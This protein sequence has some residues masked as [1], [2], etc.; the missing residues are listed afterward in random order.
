MST[1][2]DRI[3]SGSIED[4][5]SVGRGTGC[6]SVRTSGS[7]GALAGNRQ[8]HPARRRLGLAPAADASFVRPENGGYSARPRN[9]TMFPRVFGTSVIASLK[10]LREIGWFLEAAEG[11]HL[12]A[13]LASR[14][15]QLL[16]SG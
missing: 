13:S 11:S 3:A 10:P 7:V 1:S 15:P 14:P 4:G 8:G 16:A 9:Q 12:A 5:E 2:L 6:A